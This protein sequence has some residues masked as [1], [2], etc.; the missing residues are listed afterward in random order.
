MTQRLLFIVLL[1]VVG[2]CD[3]RPASA[4]QGA[5]ARNSRSG[6]EQRPQP[7]PPAPAA[8]AQP[9]FPPDTDSVPARRQDAEHTRDELHRILD[10]YPRAVGEVLRRDPSL[11]ARPDYMASYPPLAQFIAQH[12]EI[13]RNVEYYFE[14]F[15]GWGRQQF[16][17]E[18][19][20]LSVLLAGMA[21]VLVFGALLSV[22]T[23]LVRAVIQHRRWVKASQVQAEVHSKLMDRMASNE[24][25]LAYIQSPAGRKF[26]EAAPIQPEA[27]A[28]SHG[29]P[30]GPII[31]SMMAGIVLS[32]VGA[33]FRVAGGSIGE[34]VQKGFNAIGVIILSL[35]IGFILSSVMAYLVSS[36]MGLFQPRR[37]VTDS[38]HA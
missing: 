34:D 36:R 18:Y 13:P 27:D 17:P 20:A 28:P 15:G 11:M 2:F 4:Q 6:A 9:A 21:G 38:T 22:L 7:T 16:E 12:P 24:E 32:T 31:W 5:D 19:E 1:A 35:G 26:L 37:A 3:P 10:L 14:G 29:A 8:V 25:L 23:W 33:G 30:V